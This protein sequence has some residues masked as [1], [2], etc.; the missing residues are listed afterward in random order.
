MKWIHLVLTALSLSLVCCDEAPS[1]ATQDTEQSN[2]SCPSPAMQLV[3]TTP[4]GGSCDTY[5]DC[6][7]VCCNCPNNDGSEYLLAWCVEKTCKT[8][9]ADCPDDPGSSL[10]P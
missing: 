10:C 7:P 1:V 9:Q 6:L 2:G 3:G 5:K 4:A 8:T